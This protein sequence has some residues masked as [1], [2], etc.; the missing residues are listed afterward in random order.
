MRIILYGAL[1]RM[2]RE[3]DAII[4]SGYKGVSVA[5]YCDV[6]SNIP[7]IYANINEITEKA[8]AVVD[9]SH[10]SHTAPLCGFTVSRHIPLV[11]ATTGQTEDEKAIIK[12]A[13]RTIPV[14][15]SPNMSS[16]VAFLNS[17]VKKAAVFFEGADI[18]IVERHHNK[19]LDS[20]SG[21]A[22]MLAETIKSVTGGAIVA[23]RDGVSQRQPGEIGISSVR[24]GNVRGVHEVTFYTQSETFTL[25]HTAES[26]SMFGEGAL[27]AAI[28]I[29]DKPPGLYG[30][31]DIFKD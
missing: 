26:R 29:K 3:V 17:L 15:F 18:E 25:T 28:F 21:T 16:G 9:F 4:K 11:I 2:G 1:G 20:P 27:G 6:F 5:A 19:K 10:H 7:D 12:E 30:M 13:S 14:F 31:D 22:K 23:G 24:G 8:D